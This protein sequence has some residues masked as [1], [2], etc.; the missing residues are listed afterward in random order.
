MLDTL[1]RRLILS[2]VLPLLIVL[3]LLGVGLVYALETQFLT[4]ALSRE[5]AGNARLLAIIASDQ[6]QIWEDPQYAQAILDDPRVQGAARVMLLDN[7]GGLVAAT[8]GDTV[9][10]AE[11]IREVPQFVTA[12]KGETA[13]RAYR[14]PGLADEVIDVMAPIVSADGNVIGV[15]RLTYRYANAFAELLQLRYLIGAV[16][17]FGI[18]LG[19]LL[20]YVLAINISIPIQQVGETIYDLARGQRDDPLPVVGPQEIRRQA[21]AV[22]ALLERLHSLE[23]AR[24]QLLA[25]L[26]HE[27]GRPLGALRSSL[28]ALTRG[29]AQDPRLLAEILEGMDQGM[30]RLQFLLEELTHLHGQVLGTLELERQPI[31]LHEWLPRVLR[32]WQELAREKEQQWDVTIPTDLPPIKADPMRIGQAIGNLLSN[33]I[34]YTPPDGTI[35]ISAGED[36]EEVWIKVCD[37]GPGVAPA[38]AD[39]IFTPF[40]RGGQE[41]RIKQGMGLG[42]SIARDVIVAHGGRIEVESAPETGSCFT[43][44]LPL[45][46]PALVPSSSS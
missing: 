8:G 2:H 19:G 6:P 14:D 25:N 7:E 20:G 22:N 33:A 15:V 17:L 21:D 34:K 18:A 44:H 32:P 37:T 36:D 28:S 27:L 3:P 1:R 30:A 13:T 5:M 39:A 23:E 29:A 40:Y 43:I 35:A 10:P 42:L 38:E 46:L 16:I 31:V 24:R 4:P 41:Q 45:S 26:V 9:S 12:L 11:E